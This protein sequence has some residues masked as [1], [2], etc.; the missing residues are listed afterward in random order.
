M[1]S[2]TTSLAASGADAPARRYTWSRRRASSASAAHTSGELRAGKRTPEGNFLSKV[3]FWVMALSARATRD[4]KADCQE[5][6]LDAGSGG[7]ES[8][9]DGDVEAE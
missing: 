8:F 1:L 3:E 7:W 6:G 4:Q 9:V 5:T 2:R